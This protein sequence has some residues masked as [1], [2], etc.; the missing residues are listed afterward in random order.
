[1]G[2]PEVELARWQRRFFQILEEFFKR[3]YGSGINAVTPSFGEWV[4]Q[5]AN[6]FASNAPSAYAWVHDELTRYYNEVPGAGIAGLRTQLGGVKLVLGGSSRFTSSHLSS[7][8]KMLL[9]ADTI[10]IPDPILPWIESQ[11]TE[12]RFRDVLAAESA[13]EL[14]H[15]KPL[16]D[17]DLPYPPVVV[18][19][20]WEKSLEAKDDQTRA[21]QQALVTGVLSTELGRSFA[22][23]EELGAFARDASADFLRL[24]DE[25]KLLIAP[26]GQIG[27]SLQ[28]SIQLYRDSIQRW[29][30]REYQEQIDALS[31]AGFVFN[32]LCERIGPMYHL[33]ENA[34]ELI[35]NP[36]MPLAVHWH[37]FQL[38]SRLFERR[39]KDLGLLQEETVA[40]IRSLETPSHRWLGDL[41]MD[42]LVQLRLRGEN[43]LFRARM[44]DFTGALQGSNLSDINRVAAEVSRAISALI[45]EHQKTIREIQEKYDRH[46]IH[47]ALLAGVT[48]AATIVPT[49]GP[50]FGGVALLAPAGK[51]A[52]DTL[53]KQ[54]DR[55][56]ASRSLM[57]VLAEASSND[58]V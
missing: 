35:A 29:R 50:L 55:R 51:F 4:R 14:L 25:K 21:G 43:E 23:F 44:R 19:P 7:V 41:P 45:L 56:A 13:F 18:F 38:C 16:V 10:F 42:G 12:E 37:Y 39:L 33:L 1:M 58:N 9:Y 46:A 17:A 6:R 24:V 11:R 54:L 27:D 32:G 22:T 52:W 5:N 53:S 48:L 31:T 47:T 34:E 40:E 57:G 26:G 36:M 20:S 8:R 3:A 2:S 15:L 49:I 28:T 30:S